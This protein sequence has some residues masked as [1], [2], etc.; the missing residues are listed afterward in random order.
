MENNYRTIRDIPF[1]L[2]LWILFVIVITTMS[3]TGCKKTEFE[4]GWKDREIVIDGDHTD[5]KNALTYIEKK[6]VSIGLLN[7]DDYLYVC[8]VPATRQI[9]NQITRLGFTLWFDAAGGK[10]KTFGIHYPL[11]MM[12]SGMSMRELGFDP[13]PGMGDPDP[14][15]MQRLIELSLSDLEIL[16]EEEGDARM[17]GV[18]QAQ[19]IDVEVGNMTETFTYELRVPLRRDEDHPFAIGVEDAAAVG[20]GFETGQ[21]DI[22]KMREEMKDRMGSGGRGGGGMGGRGRGGRGGGRMAGAPPG[23]GRGGGMRGGSM[24]P[25][26]PD[27]L[28]VWVK[29]SLAADTTAVSF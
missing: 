1:A 22:E 4:S 23:G 20:V 29:V 11:G 9:Q 2:R 5:W 8:L 14:E 13:R 16:G 18:D 28:K 6:K 21:I 3:L 15:R 27:P 26:I 25:D 10:K 12:N 19:G 17:M 7:D 24:Q